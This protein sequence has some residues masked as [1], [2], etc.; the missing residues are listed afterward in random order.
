MQ[1][2]LL[3]LPRDSAGWGARMGAGV[4]RE[5]GVSC[6]AEVSIKTCGGD[7]RRTNLH[8]LAIDADAGEKMV[9]SPLEILE[10]VDS[11]VGVQGRRRGGRTVQEVLDAQETR[12]EQR[13]GRECRGIQRGVHLGTRYARCRVG[14]RSLV[15][16]VLREGCLVDCR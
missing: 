11:G 7:A 5:S 10:A 6:L 15:W 16:L 1:A 12:L 2:Q 9:E 13:Y 8:K 4:G 3:G 14:G